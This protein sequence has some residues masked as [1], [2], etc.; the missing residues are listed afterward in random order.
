MKKGIRVC[1]TNWLINQLII[2][3]TYARVKNAKHHYLIGKDDLR[4]MEMAVK[5]RWD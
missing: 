1:K 3:V 5:A 4:S 2:T